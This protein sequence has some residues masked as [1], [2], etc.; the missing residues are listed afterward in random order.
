[1]YFHSCFLFFLFILNIPISL[2]LPWPEQAAGE[3]WTTSWCVFFL[4][5]LFSCVCIKKERI[6]VGSETS[7]KKLRNKKEDSEKRRKRKKTRTGIGVH[8]TIHTQALVDHQKRREKKYT[9]QV[10]KTS[11]SRT[12][13]LIPPA[14]FCVLC[15]NFPASKKRTHNFYPPHQKHPFFFF[16]VVF[17]PSFNI[18]FF[19]LGC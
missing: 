14:F 15:N 13:R 12:R 7:K 11:V 5:L 4:F 6:K 19:F 3:N 18:R 17:F 8:Y 10:L 9:A 2:C 16:V 1:M